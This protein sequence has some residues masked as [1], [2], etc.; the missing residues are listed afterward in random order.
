MKKILVIHGPNLDRLGRR[1][2]H[3]YGTTSL[4]AVNRRL[5]ERA[6]ELGLE[7]RTFQSNH[8]GAIVDALGLAAD[9]V[10]GVII[11][12][13]ALTHYSVAVR[14]AL[15]ALEVPCVEVHLTN[16][17]R[18]ATAGEPFRAHS[19]TAAVCWGVIGGFGP[20]SYLLALEALARRLVR[21]DARAAEEGGKVRDRPAGGASSPAFG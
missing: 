17:Y 2:P 13:G 12:P 15:A 3:L 16:L 21:E 5:E 19:V 4:Q 9:E 14:D 10:D 11:N 8:E 18:R 7:L 20:E 6:R 1:E